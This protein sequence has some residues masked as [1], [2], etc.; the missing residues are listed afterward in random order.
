MPFRESREPKNL[1][2][3]IGFQEKE[4]EKEGEQSVG[5]EKQEK[6][7][8]REVITEKGSVYKY[9]PDGRTQRFKT[10]TGELNEK[11]DILVYIPPFDLIKEQALKLFPGIFKSI[12][13]EAQYE[14]L[15]RDYFWAEG[16]TIRVID[17]AGNEIWNS[18][19][20]E[21][22]DRAYL[23]LI[24]KEDSSRSFTLPLSKEPKIGYQAFDARQYKDK[25]GETCHEG[26]IGHK[27]KE[28]K[29]NE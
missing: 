25:D 23:A 2:S 27:V 19:D 28:I 10:A 20:M 5:I 16:R 11:Q 22:A 29:Y 26:H 12:K 6:P 14:Q 8:P 15:L 3:E 7:K 24:D 17:Q 18:E 21:K 13:N 9:L 1:E 4:A